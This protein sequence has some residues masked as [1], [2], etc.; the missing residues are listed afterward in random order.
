MDNE[1]NAW[2]KDIEQAI[3]ENQFF[4]TRCKEFQGLS[5]RLKNQKGG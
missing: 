3:I 1:V 4:H 2:L 5:K